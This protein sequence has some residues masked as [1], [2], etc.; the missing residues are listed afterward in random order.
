MA[1]PTLPPLQ[2]CSVAVIGLGYVGLPLAVE[3]ATKRMCLRTRRVMSRQVIGFDIDSKRIE[4][5]E[6]GHDHTKEVSLESLDQAVDLHFT[7]DSG[8]LAAADVFI[9][10]VPTP[11]DPSRRPDLTAL[12]KASITVGHA[13]K[14]RKKRDDTSVPVV[15][16]ESTVYPGATEEICIPLL[17]ANSG[18]V[19]NRDFY[20]GYSP[21]R[22]NPGDQNHRF[23][24][25]VKVTSGSTDLAAQWIDDFYGS[26]VDAGTYAA[27]R[28]VIAEAAKVIENTQRDLN[29]ALVNELAIIFRLM[30]IDV[31]DVLEAAGTKWN[32]LPFKPGL[33]GGHC[34]GVDP[35]YLTYKAE[36]LGYHPQIVLAGRRI[37]DN[38]ANWVV[39]QLVIEMARAHFPI[40]GAKVLVLG[41]TFK[42]NC[43]DLRN[44]KVFDVLSA[45]QRYAIDVSVVDPWA[46]CPALQESHGLSVL[47][48][49]PEGVGLF[50]AILVAVR[51]QQFIDF[52]TS[53]WKRLVGESGLLI[54]LK[55]VIPRELN[56][57]RL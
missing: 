30:G 17:E 1:P 29:I 15:I 55:G 42:E 2:T 52:D 54:D 46:D 44:S 56:P 6:A 49:L 36:L 12:K 39:E 38:H 28:I 23:T 34:I 19:C 57:I 26:V 32:F 11:I 50:D 51:H 31:L 8:K 7:S 40:G 48:S 41:I 13:L 47:P 24:S 27:G 20:C 18:L 53:V 33:V 16:F 5:L 21:E 22:I 37:N 43:P 25:I 10:A 35:Y 9:V 14:I 3:F 4:A 45:L